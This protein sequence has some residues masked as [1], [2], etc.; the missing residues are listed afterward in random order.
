MVRQSDV[1]ARFFDQPG[2]WLPEQL[3]AV[4][5]KLEAFV[6]EVIQSVNF[7]VTNA[8]E[9]AAQKDEVFDPKVAF[10]S[11]EGIRELEQEVTLVS[12]R[13]AMRDPT[14][15]HFNVEPDVPPS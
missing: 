6:D 1:G 3:D 2:L 12:R 10:K 14:D 5:A 15:Y 4:L 11:R 7:F 9:E 13:L 8:A